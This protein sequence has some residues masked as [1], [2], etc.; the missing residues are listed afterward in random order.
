MG[1]VLF[2]GAV[3][4]MTVAL[5][6]GWLAEW[7]PAEAVAPVGRAVAELVGAPLDA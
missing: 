2:V 4:A 3:A 5:V 1:R 7:D 6:L